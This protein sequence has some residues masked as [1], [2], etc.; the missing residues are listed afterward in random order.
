MEAVFSI[1]AARAALAHTTA[2]CADLPQIRAEKARC[3]SPRSVVKRAKFRCLIFTH[4]GF[5]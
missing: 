3:M 4:L 5:V 2:S 1:D